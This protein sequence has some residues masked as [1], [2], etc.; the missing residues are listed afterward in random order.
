MSVLSVRP[1]KVLGRYS[2]AGGIQ[3]ALAQRGWGVECGK[4]GMSG[5]RQDRTV[6]QGSG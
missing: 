4:S 5:E 3:S 2:G 6:W 1:V